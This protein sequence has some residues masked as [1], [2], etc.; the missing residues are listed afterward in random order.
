MRIP[1]MIAT[2]VT[3]T[4]RIQRRRGGLPAVGLGITFA[5]ATIPSVYRTLLS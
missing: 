3:A 2:T 1:T 5:V 4:A